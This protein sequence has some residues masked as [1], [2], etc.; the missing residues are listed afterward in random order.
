MFQWQ[1]DQAQ[2][3]CSGSHPVVLSTQVFSLHRSHCQV[4]FSALSGLLASLAFW[5]HKAVRDLNL[6]TP[7]HF[8]THNQMSMM[9]MIASLRWK[10]PSC[11]S[12]ICDLPVDLQ[13]GRE[14]ESPQSQQEGFF[15]W[16][17][18]K[19]H[20]LLLADEWLFGDWGR[21]FDKNPK[22]AWCRVWSWANLRFC[23]SYFLFCS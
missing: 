2:T 9:V 19:I 21:G 22:A 18:L 13:R 1:C 20:P 15:F 16:G 7:P 11:C 3:L 5:N 8:G 23:C 10:V 6:S 4:P 17:M 12:Y 14:K